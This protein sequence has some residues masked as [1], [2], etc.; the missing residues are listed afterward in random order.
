MN[1]IKLELN[2]TAENAEKVKMFIDSLFSETPVSSLKVVDAEEVRPEPAKA[3]KK[4][5]PKAATKAATKVKVPEMAA[6]AE[7]E[8]KGADLDEFEDDLTGEEENEEET[9]SKDDIK[10]VQAKKIGEHRD[11]MV[12]WLKKHGANGI[13][14]LDEKHFSA[15]FNFL[16]GLA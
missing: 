12:K 14:T 2:V 7:A 9:V 5:A 8:E 11:E 1:A 6:E 13:S 10:A 15:Y 4:A 3:P 16:N